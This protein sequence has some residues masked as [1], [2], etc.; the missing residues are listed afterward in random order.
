MVKDFEN[1]GGCAFTWFFTGKYP[2][3][4]R[5]GKVNGNE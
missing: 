1:G 2:N 3:K 5:E 4:R